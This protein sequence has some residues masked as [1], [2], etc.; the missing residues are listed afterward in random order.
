MLLLLLGIDPRKM[1]SV[2]NLPRFLKDRAAFRAA[3][4]RID[5]ALPVLADYDDQ[6]GSATLSLTNAAGNF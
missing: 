2:R 6:A 4:G 5:Y 1:R 3:G